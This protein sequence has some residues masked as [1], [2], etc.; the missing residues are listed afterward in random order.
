MPSDRPP[1]DTPP[2]AA[3]ARCLVAVVPVFNE[4]DNLPTLFA[5]TLPV[6][7]ALGRPFELVLV[8]DGSR[9]ATLEM[10]LETEALA[11]AGIRLT[12]DHHEGVAAFKE[13]RPPK[14]EGR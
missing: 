5:R 14:F 7:R 3:P 1:T 9:D 6:L 10:L 11:M 13:K 12:H 8:D 2:G 4:E